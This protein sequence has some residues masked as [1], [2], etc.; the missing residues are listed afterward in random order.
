LQRRDDSFPWAGESGLHPDLRWGGADAAAARALLVA[1]ALVGLP[2][3]AA[4]PTVP[5]FVGG[6]ARAAIA[7]A[8]AGRA[9]PDHIDAFRSDAGGAETNSTGAHYDDPAI[10]NLG[11]EDWETD[12][13][14]AVLYD[15]S[16][17]ALGRALLALPEDEVRNTLTDGW[18]HWIDPATPT[19]ELAAA[20]DL[21]SDRPSRIPEGVAVCP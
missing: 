20:F 7:A 4:A 19:S 2:E 5:C 16:D 14:P 9:V 3:P 6:Q 17:L 11:E 13:D 21:R 10:T 12:S 18:A 8:L 15:E 1:H